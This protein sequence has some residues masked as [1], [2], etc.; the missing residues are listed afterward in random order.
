MDPYRDIVTG[1]DGAIV[2]RLVRKR[3]DNA[4]AMQVSERPRRTNDLL[5][6][7]KPGE[8]PLERLKRED[9]MQ[10]YT[11]ERLERGLQYIC[12]TLERE[13]TPRTFSFLNLCK[14]HY[15]AALEEENPS[16]ASCAV[17]QAMDHAYDSTAFYHRVRRP[18][19]AAFL[20]MFV[21]LRKL[22]N[23]GNYGDFLGKS[24]QEIRAM[25]EIEAAKQSPQQAE[26]V[27]DS[28]RELPAWSEIANGLEGADTKELR[29][30]V[31]TAC[32]ILN[33][34]PN[35][36]GDLVQEW[37]DR[38][39]V[40]HDQVRK[41]VRE[42]NWWSLAKQLCRDIKELPNIYTDP[43]TRA[44]FERAMVHI[45]D[46]YFDVVDPEGASGW[47]ANEHAKVLSL[48]KWEKA[49]EKREKP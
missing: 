7:E 20:G 21:K 49:G 5:P 6:P 30:H 27:S 45:R 12:Q 18:G 32:D 44:A 3:E 28:S 37:A 43:D 15:K 25:L 8:P 35:H 19:E 16:G 41:Y 34:D 23:L 10:D 24:L 46:E 22:E 9:S 29:K 13:L 17:V 1:K 39:V 31:F 40:A 14:E 26:A 11:Q 4:K 2:R 36:M 48:Q 38:K 33:L 42:C 47:F